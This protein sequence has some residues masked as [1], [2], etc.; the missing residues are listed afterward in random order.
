MVLRHHLFIDIVLIDNRSWLLLVLRKIELDKFFFV[1]LFCWI[2]NKFCVFGN[3]N[4]RTNLHLGSVAWS[5]QVENHLF[6]NDDFLL[7]WLADR[8]AVSN[9]ASLSYFR[10]RMFHFIFDFCCRFGER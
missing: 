2:I 10:E 9:A 5:I 1:D 3:R 4:L 7:D 8:L 6:L